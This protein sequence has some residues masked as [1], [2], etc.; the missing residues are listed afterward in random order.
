MASSRTSLER[1]LTYAFGLVVLIVVAMIP[2][3]MW[4]MAGITNEARDLHHTIVKGELAYIK[5]AGEADSLQA[6]S[7][8]AATNP[9]ASKAGASLATA[10]SL[11]KQFPEDAR[12]MVDVFCPIPANM[13]TADAATSTCDQR[14]R[15][16]QIGK[17]VDSFNASASAYDF[18]SLSA[19][20]FLITNK[21]RDALK[22]INGP[23]SDAYTKQRGDGQA[24]LN[25][26]SNDSDK[27]WNALLQARNLGLT[28]FVI[29]AIVATLIAILGMG[30]FR[31]TML[32]GVGR[33][34]DV[35]ESMGRGNLRQRVGWHGSDLLGRLAQGVD[36]LAE[37][38]STMIGAIQTSAAT[39]FTA[40]GD[41]NS[42]A[43]EVE[44][45]VGLDHHGGANRRR[46]G[47]R[48]RCGS[49]GCGR[50]CGR[51]GSGGSGRSGSDGLLHARELG[52]HLAGRH[53]ASA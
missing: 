38:L 4:A 18:Q 51:G 24:L 33:C 44:E 8:E 19:V 21:K 23:S 46:R 3:A 39:V 16:D 11:I 48:G 50:R 12:H 13:K 14:G 30:W 49:R 52:E 40:I 10:K 47:A 37:R 26:L 43:F 22:Q 27:R 28:V 32:S 15:K 36:E 29:G 42:T 17:L 53:D 34:V 41:N 7:L 5:V 25:A 1:G 45:R 31:R 35:F 2:V 6:A 20:Q 9:D